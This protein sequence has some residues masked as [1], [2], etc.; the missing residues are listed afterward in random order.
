M[1]IL[2]ISPPVLSRRARFAPSGLAYIAAVLKKEGHSV[3][4]IDAFDLSWE[5][6]RDRIM[7]VH[8][9]VV[10]ISCW[11][12]GRGQAFKT[13]HIARECSPESKIVFGGQHA[14]FLPRQM[15]EA[16]DADF[17]VL[18]EGEETIVELVRALE[19]GV[20]FSNIKGIA[21]KNGDDIIINSPRP[22][23]TNLDSL[24]FPCYDDFDLDAYEGL[25]GSGKAIGIITSRGCPFNCN[26]CS[27]T[28]F[29]TRKW[30]YRSAENV[31]SEIEYVY[32]EL[33]VREIVIYDDN[34][35]T[36]KDRAIEICKGIIERKLNLVWAASANVR[37]VDQ[38][39]LT[40]MGK[41]GCCEVRY[42]VES[43]SPTILKNINKRQTI[44][45]IRNAFRWTREVG[46]M[47]HGYLM[48][49]CPG[50]TSQTI[51]DTVK[52]MR[53]IAPRQSPSAGILWI[54]PGTE[55]YERAKS[56]GI[57]SDNSW[58]E[59]EDEIFYT[60]EYSMDEL[61][62]LQMQLLKGLARNNGI[63]KFYVFLLRKKLKSVNCIYRVYCH[64]RNNLIRLW[65]YFAK[66][67]I[68]T[69]EQGLKALLKLQH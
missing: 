25:H 38:E 24:P 45:Q 12:I 52:L 33:A 27:S 59:G 8:P 30:R 44:D 9:D 63:L 6:L 2:L 47:P 5:S 18:G 28:Q 56:Y 69:R 21:Y 49:G 62:K 37:T 23:I 29:W 53:E 67:K 16:D 58:L 22:L 43:G 48:V 64:Y 46:M 15:F 55:I 3:K 17:V 20:D 57:I 32:N 39:V 68:L 35:T 7:E 36:K 10:G 40:W 13:A 54:L 19:Y 66:R 31:L 61:K 41:A 14:T 4:C 50:E 26:Y 51:N 11:T 1:N 34:F 42:G 65:R 60:A